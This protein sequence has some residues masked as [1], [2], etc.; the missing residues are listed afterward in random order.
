MRAVTRKRSSAT[1]NEAARTRN[2][3]PPGDAVRYPLDVIADRLDDL[4]SQAGISVPTIAARIWPDRGETARFNWYKKVGLKG[5]SFEVWEIDRA[6]EVIAELAPEFDP[7]P[8]FPFISF[9]Y[10]F[11]LAASAA[12]A[13]R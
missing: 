11:A 5:S 8:G 3:T 4:R 13:K 9:E 7:P 6:C 10:A 2:R 12:R 1:T